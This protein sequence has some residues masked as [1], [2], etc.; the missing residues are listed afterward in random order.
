MEQTIRVPDLKCDH[1]AATVRN[2]LAKVDG[3]Q[4]VSVDVGA[5]LVRVLG[6]AEPAALARAIREAGFSALA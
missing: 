4:E 1:C 3:V 2:A 5:K 6:Q